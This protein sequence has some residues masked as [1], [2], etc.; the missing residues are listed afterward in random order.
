MINKYKL[1]KYYA[2]LKN[3]N[4][5]QANLVYLK[6]I[7]FYKKNN[8]ILIGGGLIDDMIKNIDI[9]LNKIEILNKMYKIVKNHDA[10]IKLI[11]KNFIGYNKDDDLIDYYKKIYNNIN[12]N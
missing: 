7:L 6:K 5:M 2:K 3:S 9:I 8:T 11:N 12:K 4:N 1:L 10:T